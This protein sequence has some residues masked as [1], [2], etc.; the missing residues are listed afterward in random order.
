MLCIWAKFSHQVMWLN[1]YVHEHKGARKNGDGYMVIPNNPKRDMTPWLGFPWGVLGEP[2][3]HGLGMTLIS[4]GSGKAPYGLTARAVGW[5]GAKLGHCTRLTGMYD[6][7]WESEKL[8]V[9]DSN[10]PFAKPAGVLLRP[11]LQPPNERQEES[12]W[13]CDGRVSDLPKSS[14][15][16]EGVCTHH[17]RLTRTKQLSLSRSW[18]WA[19]WGKR[20]TRSR[21]CNMG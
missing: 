10:N 7:M 19:R 13:G 14:P 21:S 4:E 16:A 3:P 20:L 12:F 1:D 15:G 11:G 6:G 9:T 8:K 5:S 17:C 2:Y 18:I